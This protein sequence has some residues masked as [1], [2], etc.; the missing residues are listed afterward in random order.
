MVSLA[1]TDVFFSCRIEDFTR[2]QRDLP[3]KLFH[4]DIHG[5]R[6]WEK[7][8][9]CQHRPGMENHTRDCMVKLSQA[10]TS[11]TGIYYFIVEGEE[12]YQSDG[13]VI[14]VRDT[15]YQPPAFKVQ[16]ALMLGFTS[17]MSVLGVLGT[18]LLLWKK[19]QISVLGKH[20]AKTCSGLK[21]TVG[22]TK[23]PAESVYTSLQRRETEVYACMK[24]ETGSPVFS[25]SPATKEKLNRF[26]DDNEFNLVYEN[27]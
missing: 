1:N 7:Q 27:L 2:L 26:E 17:L 15:V 14:L 22:T 4:T 3:V 23:P 5:R 10:N 8:I 19:K 16:E 18:A 12:T 20:T 24:E 11:A 21:S 6:R 25:Q 9:N 13:V